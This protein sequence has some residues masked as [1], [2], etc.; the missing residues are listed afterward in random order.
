MSA[1]AHGIFWCT[2]RPWEQ[3]RQT[4]IRWTQQG[5]T[6]DLLPSTAS[7]GNRIHEYGGGSYVLCGDRLLYSSISDGSLWLISL[8]GAKSLKCCVP[9]GQNRWFGDFSWDERRKVVYAIQEDHAGKDVVNSIVAIHLDSGLITPVISGND[10]YLNP[11]ISPSGTKL[12]YLAW[13]NPEM[14]W[15]GAELHVMD[16]IS[17]DPCSEGKTR[18]IAGEPGHAAMAH[19]WMPN[20]ELVYTA[21]R[22]GFWNLHV[23]SEHDGIRL[24]REAHEEHAF[25]QWN[26][27]N[28]SI[29]VLEK[30]EF[31]TAYEK[32]GSMHLAVSGIVPGT[33][34]EL[35]TPLTTGGRSLAVHEGVVILEGGSPLLPHG[36]YCV[37]T[38]TADITPLA[39]SFDLPL[40]GE[41]EVPLATTEVIHNA[42]GDEIHVV[43]YRPPFESP[44]PRVLIRAHGGPT[45]QAEPEL[46][47]RMVYWTSRGYTV[48]QVNYRGSTGFGSDYRRALLGA[49]GVI[50]VEDCITAAHVYA[51][52]LQAPV[53][54]SG[55]SAGGFTVLSALMRDGVFSGGACYYGVADLTLLLHDFHKFEDKYLETLIAPREDLAAYRE[56]SP[57]NH[58]KELHV[59][60]IFFHGRRD[61]VVP[62]TQTEAMVRSLVEAGQVVASVIYDD[63]HHGF[64]KEHAISYSLDAEYS[65]YEHLLGAPPPQLHPRLAIHNAHLLRS[66]T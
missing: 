13:N 58:L 20:E 30:D 11:R 19:L 37:D 3:G 59:P 18:H 28:H 14:P 56:R 1:N 66:R 61:S 15:E 35:P 27:G 21:D 32:D 26:I 10:F 55:G 29:A 2:S 23:W 40:P 22:N 51:K 31:I 12:A 39:K 62:V 60:V 63:E 17:E 53:F 8:L 24:L 50:D 52:E 65:F 16:C 25:P 48:V 38:N 44:T 64:R 36:I 45:S 4:I 49:W 42:E 33:W 5:S 46:D 6:E 9:G 41:V 47:L 57:I 43:V 34:H 7:V 54:I